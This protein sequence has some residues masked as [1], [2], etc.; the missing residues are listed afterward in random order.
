MNSTVSIIMPAFN[1]AQFISDAINS[2]IN[3]SFSDWELI[4]INDGSTD[5]TSE[6]LNKFSSKEKR[7]KIINFKKNL[8][9]ANAR[10]IGLQ[11]SAGKFIAFLDS[12][13]FW[14]EDKLIKQLVFMK[15]K[16]CKFSF[17]DYYI[18]SEEK[19]VLTSVDNANIQTIDYKELLKTNRIGCLTVMLDRS[20]IHK[21]TFKDIKHED[22]DFWLTILNED[23]LLAFR[24]PEKL[25]FYR[26]SKGSISS[27]KIK[28]IIWVWNIYR[29]GQGFS[30]LKTN[31]LFLHYMINTFKKKK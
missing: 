24:I 13:D 20:I 25:A 12:D 4:V 27:N 26:K 5:E 30:V 11:Q 1:S 9:I 8:G 10:N 31:W 16:Q 2:V 18:V 22:Y 14:S 21:Q 29:K 23:E 7:I 19:K 6:I 28:S 3:Q 15:K 17:T